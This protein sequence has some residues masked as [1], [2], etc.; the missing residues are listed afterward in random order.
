M[1]RTMTSATAISPS[2]SLP[3]RLFLPME[4]RTGKGE[5]QNHK[6]TSTENPISYVKI[7][8]LKPG[9]AEPIDHI[10]HPK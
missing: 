5:Q 10:K 6:W 3:S 4:E 9:N 2:P 7:E 8:L 1:H